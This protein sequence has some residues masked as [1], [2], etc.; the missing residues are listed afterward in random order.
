MFCM[1][2]PIYSSFD[3]WVIYDSD[4]ISGSTFCHLLLK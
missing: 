1:D 4:Y 3:F 2:V